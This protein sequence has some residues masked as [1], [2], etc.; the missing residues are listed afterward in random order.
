[1]MRS[2]PPPA[3]MAHRI[4]RQA[5]FLFKRRR[6]ARTKESTGFI[7]ERGTLGRGL[8]TDYTVW[9][10]IFLENAQGAG[11]VRAVGLPGSP[12]ARSPEAPVWSPRR[13]VPPGHGKPAPPVQPSLST[14]PFH[15]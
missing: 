6:T 1:M 7:S 5:R 3:M 12:G 9:G 2:A 10:A 8:Y 11:P 14:F 15:S 4:A 13:S